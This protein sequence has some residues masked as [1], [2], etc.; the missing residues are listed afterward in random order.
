[1]ITSVQIGVSLV[2]L[3]GLILGCLAYGSKNTKRILESAQIVIEVHKDLV[4]TC[5]ADVLSLRNEVLAIN[6]RLNQAIIERDAL[7]R[8]NEALHLEVARSKDETLNIKREANELTK[9]IDALTIEVRELR[10]EV[11]AGKP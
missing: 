1:M 9:K 8:E 10:S 4:S 2:G 5:Q 11:D 6:N 7:I 3:S